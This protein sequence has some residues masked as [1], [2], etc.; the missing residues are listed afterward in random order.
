MTSASSTSQEHRLPTSAGRGPRRIARPAALLVAAVLVAAASYLVAPVV[1]PAATPPAAPV[2]ALPGDVAPVAGGES[3]AAGATVD[4]RLPVADRVAFWSSRVEATPGD[5]LSLVQLALAEA[6]QARLTIDLDGYERAL[7]NI[8][9]SL[10]I[11]P[12]YPPTIRARGSIRF[13]LHDFAGALTDAQTVLG[14][15]PSDTAAMAIRG[16][17]LLELGRPAD[18][19]G[20]YERLATLAPGPWLDVRLARLASATGNPSRAVALARKALDAAPTAD[21]A[22][23]GFYAFALGEYARLSGDSTTARSGYERAL[24]LRATDVAALAGLARIDAF[25]GRTQDA[26]AGLEVASGIVPQPETL[27]LLGDLQAAAGDSDQASAAFETVRF[28]ERLGAIQGVVYDR[29]LLR[30][31]LDH[32][33]AS[34]DILAAARASL[35]AR[36]DS[37]GH[38]LVAWALH[39]LGR[40][41][42]AAN[43]IDGARSYGADDAR[44]RFHA[45]AIAIAN[46]DHGGGRALIASALAAGPALDPIERLEAAHLAD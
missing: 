44:L 41:G 40:D 46:G 25:E 28:I 16:D 23:A 7:A 30:F 4:G 17:A 8:D 18:A 21:P 32:G 2:L 9:R 10:A 39:R 38:D 31:E 34:A 1:R 5:F 36:P 29:Q 14:A 3:A 37:T 35:A 24:A 43:E 20:V 27:A 11:V 12:A 26:M 45:G 22:E 15:S 33:G 19:A 42:E 6:E 13:A